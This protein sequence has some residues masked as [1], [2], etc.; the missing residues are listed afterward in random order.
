MDVWTCLRRIE[1][2]GPMEPSVETLRSLQLAFLLTVPFENLDIHLG[3]EISLSSEAV[4]RKIVAERRGGF[5]YECNGLFYDLLRELEFAVDLLSARMVL[6][7]TPSP[8]FDHMVLLVR[9]DHEYLVDVGNGRS[10][11]E[12]LRIDGANES[13]SEGY[14]YRIQRHGEDYALCYWESDSGWLPRYLFSRK[15]RERREFE[16]MC[17]YHQVSPDS[18][19]TQKRLVTMVTANGRVTL[20]GMRLTIV[21][22]PKRRQ[23]ELTSDEEY[24]KCLVKYFGI[25]L[26]DRAW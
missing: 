5:C 7:P 10:C 16:E 19:F 23:R 14:R 2:A 22:E 8:E 3:R 1:Y 20:S 25:N 21:D 12:P 18:P 13:C 24:A 17:R 15:P 26:E 4:Y 9:L 6:G 11:R